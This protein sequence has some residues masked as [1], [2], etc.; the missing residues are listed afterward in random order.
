MCKT[1]FDYHFR[2]ERGERIYCGRSCASKNYIQNGVYDKWRLRKNSIKGAMSK[3]MNLSCKNQV[4]LQPHLIKKGKGKLC[5]FQCEKEYF[6]FLHKGENGPFYGK[7]HSKESLEK[8]KRTLAKNYPG[9]TNAF[10]L[11]K[12]RTKTKPQISIF[13]YLITHFKECEFEIEKRVCKD[14]KEYYADIVSQKHKLIIEFYGD[15]WHCNPKKYNSDFF[16]HVKRKTALDIWRLD[17]KRLDTISSFGYKIL[18]IWENEFKNDSWKKTITN[19]V[20]EN[21]KKDNIIYIRSSVNNH[22]SA[23]VKL[24]ELLENRGIITTTQLEM[25]NVIVKKDNSL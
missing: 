4:Y 16:H 15:Y 2:S 9:V 13:E 5:S 24:G 8:Q 20:E 12:K 1:E 23:D 7:K 11:A 10:S 21:A 6:S 17:E 22:S 25:T 3:C 19:W 14:D 18:V